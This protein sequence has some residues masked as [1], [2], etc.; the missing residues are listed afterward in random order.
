MALVSAADFLSLGRLVIYEELRDDG[1]IRILDS[2]QK[3]RKF[4]KDFFIVFLSHQWLAW[5]KPDP[6]GVHYR[7]MCDALQ[8]C[9]HMPGTD[10]KMS[11]ENIYVW[12]D[13]CSISQDLNR[14]CVGIH[15][16]VSF[17]FHLTSETCDPCFGRGSCPATSH[18]MET[19][20]RAHVPR[21]LT[22]S[23]DPPH[24]AGLVSPAASGG[25]LLLKVFGWRPRNS[26]R[27]TRIP[28][29]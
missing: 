21:S 8:N 14:V 15:R 17:L 3:I 11:L 19:A 25:Y 1:K 9:A 20:A 12:V 10:D 24:T 29:A 26:Q 16:Q 18:S 13:V 28:M 6:R 4:Q 27:Y 23:E 7:A 5:G 2:L 22:T